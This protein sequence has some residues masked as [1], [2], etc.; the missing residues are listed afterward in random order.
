[1]RTIWRAVVVALLAYMFQ[2]PLLRLAQTTSYFARTT[3]SIAARHTSTT[4]AAAN[5]NMSEKPTGPIAKSGLE[6][7]TFGTPNGHKAS[8]MLEELKEAYGTNYVYVSD[9]IRLLG[10]LICSND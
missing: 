5:N 10:W 1:M 4:T 7:L 3:Q 2:S 8:I 9:T 6:L